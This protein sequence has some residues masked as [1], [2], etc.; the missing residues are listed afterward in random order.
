MNRLVER[1]ADTLGAFPRLPAVFE[2]TF[3]NTLL[4]TV[5]PAPDGATFVITGDIP[6]MWLRDS[7][8]QVRPYLTPAAE[9]EGLA[10]L[11][12]GVVRRQAACVLHDPY[13]NAFN[14][15]PNGRHHADDRTDTSDL[16]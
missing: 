14:E 15:A 2:A 1:V 4:T 6:A 11:I 13:A 10:S 16:V 12:V 3:A 5:R 9:D 8:A 7:A